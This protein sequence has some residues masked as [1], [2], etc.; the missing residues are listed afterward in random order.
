MHSLHASEQ[1]K[2]EIIYSHP[3]YTYTFTYTLYESDTGN[4]QVR[5]HYGRRKQK[6]RI[7]KSL[8]LHSFTQKPFYVSS[9]FM[10]L[11]ECL[12]HP[13][14]KP[15]TF[16][17]IRYILLMQEN[18]SL[19][20]RD[21]AEPKPRTILCCRV[22]AFPHTGR[23]QLVLEA[24]TGNY[25]DQ[26]CVTWVCTSCTC[27]SHFCS[28]TQ[29]QNFNW[30]P[31]LFS[32]EDGSRWNTIYKHQEL[33]IGHLLMHSE[34]KHSQTQRLPDTSFICFYLKRKRLEAKGAMNRNNGVGKRWSNVLQH[35]T[36]YFLTSFFYFYMKFLIK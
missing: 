32:S 35:I 31:S 15:F 19:E 12:E 2:C 13:E 18:L 16:G 24:G 34:L 10:F 29:I 33:S 23:L 11:L 3:C 8:L 9:L 26:S 36:C 30:G 28:P 20:G 25:P 17:K 5:S 1:I 27:S 21:W 6:K 7:K 14:K 22:W 4:L